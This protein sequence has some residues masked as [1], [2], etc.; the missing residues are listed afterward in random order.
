M[1]YQHRVFSIAVAASM[2]S[3]P[4]AMSD[5]IGLQRQAL[6][7]PASASVLLESDTSLVRVPLDFARVLPLDTPAKTI[8]IG[9]PL[10]A[11]G[12]L[13]DQNTLILT[14][15]TIGTT[16]LIVSGE[17]NMP[18]SHFLVQVV[19]NGVHVTTVHNGIQQQ[20][21]SCS[22]S[23]VALAPQNAKPQQ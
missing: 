23:C 13:S 6:I 19:P 1:L 9:N 7:Q 4:P 14:G 16:N 11:D 15:K 3:I 12:L 21:F 17:G 20:V 22:N 2:L 18:P 8:I 5:E 10:I